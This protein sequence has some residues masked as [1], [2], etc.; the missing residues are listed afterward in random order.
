MIP[1]IHS[2]QIKGKM[3]NTLLDPRNDL[4]F[5]LLFANSLPLLSDLIN[6]V[7]SGETPVDV[8]TV[9]NPHVAAVD[10]QGKFIILDILAKDAQGHF[11]NIEMQM[12]SQEKWSTRSM[13]Y[14]AKTLASQLK[15]GQKYAAL[16]PVIGIHLLGYDLFDAPDQ[17]LWCFEMRDRVN[18]LVRLGSELQLNIIELRKADRLV[19]AGKVPNQPGYVTTPLAAWVLYFEHWKEE[20]IMNQ[21]AYP[22]VKEALKQLTALSA[23]EETRRLADMRER[24]LMAERTEIDAAE[25]RGELRTKEHVLKRLIQSGMSEAQA[26]AIVDI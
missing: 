4:V 15:A 9:L 10:A 26:R 19:C 25:A 8:I 20:N 23:D 17:A 18:P 13:Y 24:A 3:D 11:Y 14:L 6:A 1:T 21:I 16:K 7:R 2:N 22:P 12:S 5:K